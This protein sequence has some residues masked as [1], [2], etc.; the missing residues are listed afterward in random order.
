MNCC[1]IE[2]IATWIEWIQLFQMFFNFIFSLLTHFSSTAEPIEL[3]RFKD[4][5]PL[6]IEPG[7]LD[8][9]MDAPQ[10]GTK[11]ELAIPATL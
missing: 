7:C 1:S 11:C 10:I 4:V 3:F 6:L 9:V 2:F 8:G 5:V